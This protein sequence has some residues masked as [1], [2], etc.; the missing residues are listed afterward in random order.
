MKAIASI[1][2]FATAAA[3]G[4]APALADEVS[5]SRAA[6][7]TASAPV[8]VK[9]NMALYGAEGNR[10]ARVYS[11]SREGNPQVILN[12]ALHTIPASTLSVVDGRLTT[13]LS[14]REIVRGK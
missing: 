13:S 9:A 8:E 5:T 14:K 3:F 10:I 1:A 7:Q 2:L 6:S 12:S 11:V 4:T